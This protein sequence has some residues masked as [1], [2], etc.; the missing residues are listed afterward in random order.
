MPS[1]GLFMS[2]NSIREVKEMRCSADH[3][4]LHETYFDVLG[5]MDAVTAAS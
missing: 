3:E 2:T 1:Y 5:K 4:G